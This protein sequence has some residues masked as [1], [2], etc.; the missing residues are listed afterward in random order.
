MRFLN[1][2]NMHQP[3]SPSVFFN[4]EN[5]GPT[6]FSFFF[7]NKK[8]ATDRILCVVRKTIGLVSLNPL[9]NGASAF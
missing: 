5:V 4:Q 8:K 3:D 1:L 9:E 7:R 2:R 6:G